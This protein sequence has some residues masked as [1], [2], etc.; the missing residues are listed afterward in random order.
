MKFLFIFLIWPAF[1]IGQTVHIK[2][3]EIFY[4]G[5]EKVEGLST[6][7][8]FSRIQKLLP[9]LVN[10]YQE[11]EKSENSIKAKG[12]LRLQTP[13]N[14]IRKVSYVINVKATDKGYEYVI[15]SVFY[16]ERE[17][18][19]KATTRSSEDVLDGISETGKVVGE[20]EK[21]LNETDMRLQKL[22]ALLRNGIN[23]H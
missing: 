23:Q 18:G 19:R 3:K 17:R 5:K 20:T 8:I 1:S 11:E 4:E 13:Y 12:Q 21:I 9:D 22:L 16:Y 6:A 15:D 14:I 7:E 2:D 10:N